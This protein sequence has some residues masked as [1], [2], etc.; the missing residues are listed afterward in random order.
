MSVLIINIFE[1]DDSTILDEVSKLDGEVSVLDVVKLSVIEVGE[2]RVDDGD[3]VSPTEATVL[4]E[5]DTVELAVLIPRLPVVEADGMSEF[6]LEVELT[7]LLL[8]LPDARVRAY[9]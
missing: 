9:I 5:A 8:L 4:V 7:L 1:L 6:E 3:D 2:L